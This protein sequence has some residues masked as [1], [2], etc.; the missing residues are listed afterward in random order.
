MGGELMQLVAPP[1][2]G[3]LLLLL[4]GVVAFRGLRD[5]FW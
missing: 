5:L 4:I 2:V 1:Q 3:E